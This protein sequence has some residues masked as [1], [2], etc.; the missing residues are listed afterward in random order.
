M[1][2]DKEYIRGVIAGVGSDASYDTLGG[3]LSCASFLNHACER[4]IQYD[5]AL[6]NAGYVEAVVSGLKVHTMEAWQH[7]CT[8]MIGMKRMSRQRE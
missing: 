3:V 6:V 1:F 5:A 7:I 8:D 4:L 2:K